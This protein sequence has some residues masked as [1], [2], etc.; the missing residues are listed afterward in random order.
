MNAGIPHR[1]ASKLFNTP[2]IGGSSY[3]GSLGSGTSSSS[4]LMKGNLKQHSQQPPQLHPKGGFDRFPLSDPSQVG[5]S[6]QHY[7]MSRGYEG[8][9]SRSSKGKASQTS[10]EPS[11]ARSSKCSGSLRANVP[12]VTL[13][14][15]RQTLIILTNYSREITYAQNG[16]Y[17]GRFACTVPGRLGYHLP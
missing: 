17:Q 1:G 2:S 7:S 6:R 13:P 14:R 16:S 11:K 9:A 8:S 4:M 10:S 12:N 3:P 5:S 15:E